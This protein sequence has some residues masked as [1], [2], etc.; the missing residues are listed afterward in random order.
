MPPCALDVFK[1]SEHALRRPSSAPLRD[2]I[3]ELRVK[4]K[5]VNYRVLYF[6]DGSG[7]A[8]LALGCTKEGTVE[9][10]DID[11]AVRYHAM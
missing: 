3:H 1:V 8:A 11:R 5:R 9:A 10:T 2:E 7:A 6:F 4:V